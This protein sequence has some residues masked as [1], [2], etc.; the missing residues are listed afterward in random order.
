V[1]A[2]CHVGCTQRELLPL[3]GKRAHQEVASLLPS[4]RCRDTP[5]LPSSDMLASDQIHGRRLLWCRASSAACVDC[6]C[7]DCRSQQ[8]SPDLGHV[9]STLLAGVRCGLTDGTVGKH[10]ALSDP[11]SA[12]LVLSLER[13]LTAVSTVSSID[14]ARL[15]VTSRAPVKASHQADHPSNRDLLLCHD[16][17]GARRSLPHQT[18]QSQDPRQRETH[19]MNTPAVSSLRIFRPRINVYNQLRAHTLHTACL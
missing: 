11:D 6:M 8:H 12:T 4:T 9:E 10:S 18:V 16:A 13:F 14:Q 17:V 3:D 19:A 15:C 1:A 5:G 7:A 2:L